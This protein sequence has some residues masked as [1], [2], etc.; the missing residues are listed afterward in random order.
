MLYHRASQLFSRDT[1]ET[2]MS[3]L[4]P[5]HISPFPSTDWVPET[6]FGKWFLSTSTW[7]K[8]V[9]TEAIVDLRKLAGER[10]Q[11]PKRMVDIGCG[12][13]LAFSLL[14]EHF[15][16]EQIIGVDVDRRLLDRAEGKTSTSK[17]D[18]RVVQSSVT[19]L[20]L[21]DNFVDVVF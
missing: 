10:A 8:Y 9:L 16:P 19:A 4:P 21:P 13:G 5:T 20:N 11:Q 2:A 17:C 3:S 7:F 15:G 12:Q 6:A 14:A 18:I 1:V